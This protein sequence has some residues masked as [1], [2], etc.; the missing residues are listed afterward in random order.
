MK[1]DRKEYIKSD[2]DTVYEI[3]L[4]AA[5]IYEKHRGDSKYSRENLKQDLRTAITGLGQEFDDSLVD[6]AIKGMVP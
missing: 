1:E 6:E 4:V 3:R 2:A 5:R